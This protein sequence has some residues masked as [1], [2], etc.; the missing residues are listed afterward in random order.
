MSNKIK[1]VQKI[2]FPKIFKAL[3]IVKNKNKYNLK[4]KNISANTINNNEVV[5]KVA[6]A[7]LN[8][9]DVLMFKGNSGLAKKYPHVPGIDCS[10]NIVHSNS[11]KFS[12]NERVMIVGRPIGVKTFGSMAEFIVAPDSWIEKIPNKMN[13]KNTIIFGTAG[14]AAMLAVNAIIKN[15]LNKNY[16][17]LVT[18]ASGGV[19]ILSVYILG[20]FGYKV[21]CMTRN[22]KKYNILKKLGSSEIVDPKKFYNAPNMPLLK[23]KFSAIIDNI[24]GE[25]ISL[26]LKQLINNGAIISV[27]NASSEISKINIMPLIL[28]GAKI[29]GINAESTSEKLRRKIWKNISTIINDKKI[30]LLYQEYNFKNSIKALNTFS[31]SNHF[32]R[33]IIKF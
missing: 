30:K 2:L 21:S 19:G 22:I 7:S 6:Y 24:G 28:R 14:L 16:P 32:G 31:S 13:L 9:K 5:V 8:Y 10:G 4:I 26:G 25:V 15:K 27:G 12:I 11:K 29:I 3:L 17:I 23:I 1:T 18:G 33:I 20:K